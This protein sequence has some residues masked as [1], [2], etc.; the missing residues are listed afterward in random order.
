MYKQA[1]ERNR[2]LHKIHSVTK[3]WYSIGTWYNPR[4][5]HLVRE[6]PYKKNGCNYKKVLK[7]RTSKRV[8]SDKY[9]LY[10]GTSYRKLIDMWWEL[11]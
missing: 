5:K 6:Y 11:F 4:T 9:N 10:N 7:R 2:R 3:D 8:R 1:K